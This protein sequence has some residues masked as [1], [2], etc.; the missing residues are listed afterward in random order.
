MPRP[1]G[2][3]MSTDPNNTH[4]SK[5]TIVNTLLEHP[6]LW[7]AAQHNPLTSNNTEAADNN[8]VNT[9]FKSLDTLL[10]QGGWPLG[11][12]IEC[13]NQQPGNGELDLFFPAIKKLQQSSTQSSIQPS[14]QRQNK[15]P[16]K[17]P[18]ANTNT[19][20]IILIAPPYLPCLEAWQQQLQQTPL[21]W[22]VKANNIP[23]RLWAA[24]QALQSNSASVVML[25]LYGNSNHK[26]ENIQT[27]QL[28]RLQLAAKKSRSLVVVLRDIQAQRQHSPAPLRL[29]LT[30]VSKSQQTVLSV[31][32][33][34]QPGHWGGQQTHIPWHSRLQY[35]SPPAEQWPV[36][37]PLAQQNDTTE[38]SGSIK[39]PPLPISTT[40]WS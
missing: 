24:E 7:Q 32:I 12:L 20:P 8:T 34:K 33:I 17:T 28:R 26:Q 23:D 25:W 29:S 36:Y 21:L 38:Y 27:A 2:N 3:N 4:D 18:T 5:K 35:R 15:A 1:D 39:Q 40:K 13:L 10:S 11:Q 14:I 22:C 37:I 30:P 9:G 6:A 16:R 31:N 19:L